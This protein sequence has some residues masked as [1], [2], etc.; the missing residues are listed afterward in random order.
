MSIRDLSYYIYMLFFFLV[1][2]I[3]NTSQDSKLKWYKR[4]CNEKSSLQLRV[5]GSNQHHRFLMF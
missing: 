1:F 3:D 5:P 4:V 2:S